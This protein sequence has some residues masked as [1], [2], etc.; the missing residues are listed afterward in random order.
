MPRSADARDQAIEFLDLR[1]IQP[2]RR[3]IH[4]DEDRIHRERP[5]NLNEPLMAEG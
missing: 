4:R 3:F 2:R 1:L 5:R